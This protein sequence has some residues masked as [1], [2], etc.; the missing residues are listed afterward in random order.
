M[1]RPT[2]IRSSA[3]KKRRMDRKERQRISAFKRDAEVTFPDGDLGTAVVETI[4]YD[5]YSLG[6]RV[7]DL[8]R[9]T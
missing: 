5:D 2:W 9:A 7:H 4:V 6:Y 1:K 8:R 3:K